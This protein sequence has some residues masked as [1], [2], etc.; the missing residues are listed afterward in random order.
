MSFEV[1]VVIPTFNR[2]GLIGATL[3]SVLAQSHP[4][5]EIIVVDDGS[6]DDTESLVRRQYPRV[7]YIRIPNSGPPAARNA[8]VQASKSEWLA[9]LD[10]DDLWKPEKL[11]AHARL[12]ELAPEVSYSFSNF[13]I[14]RDQQWS[15]QT[16]FDLAPPGYF[17][18][19][20][21]R[22]QPGFF[23]C[24]EPMLIPV[25]HFQPVFVSA[26]L[27]TRSLFETV[28]RWDESFGRNPTEDFEFLLR[29]VAHPLVGIVESPLV[30]IRKHQG[31]FSGNLLKTVLGQIEI[32]HYVADKNA[33]PP[34][35]LEVI[36][37]QIIER[38]MEAA[39]VAFETGDLGQVRDVL[40][41][42][43]PARLSGTLRMKAA[44]CRMPAPVGRLARQATLALSSALGHRSRTKTF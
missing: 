18:L 3:D 20:G 2:V 14:V 7:K 10:S 32:L 5:A 35:V 1:G 19:P 24:E 11:E 33:Y 29:C 16:K 28:G 12:A 36:H 42:V 22:P 27:M 44:I 43:P 9:F 25:L 4:A 17:D 15:R 41:A 30:G 21:R 38:S 37:D 6:T 8:G 31:N 39:V 13:R 40:R 34:A 23:V 26:I